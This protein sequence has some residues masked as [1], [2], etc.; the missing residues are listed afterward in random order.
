[1]GNRPATAQVPETEPVVALNQNADVVPSCT[2][3][4]V[5]F[6]FSRLFLGGP[7]E[8]GGTMTRQSRMR[9]GKTHKACSYSGSSPASPA[10]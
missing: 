9:K 5:P 4:L 7:F 3:T 1:M 2:H 6:G 8:P 10:V